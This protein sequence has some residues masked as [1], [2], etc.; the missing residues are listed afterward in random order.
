M[1][2]H[3]FERHAIDRLLVIVI[4]GAGSDFHAQPVRVPDRLFELG[5]HV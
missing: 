3:D 5:H 2:V 1:Q 4:V